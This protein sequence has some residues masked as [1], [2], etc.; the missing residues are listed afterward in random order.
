RELAAA[1]QYFRNDTLTKEALESQLYLGDIA[2]AENRETDAFNIYSD[3]KNNAQQQQFI[4]LYVMAG[5][6]FSDMLLK[7]KDYDGAQMVLGMT[8]TTAIQLE[9]LEAQQKVLR[10]L[11]TL[12][13]QINDYENA[14]AISTQYR[15]VSDEIRSLQ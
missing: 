15:R 13:V 10:S 14:Y 7:R 5:Q 2:L 12:F 1:Y 6:R 11:Q 3:V 4:D 9:D 8:Y